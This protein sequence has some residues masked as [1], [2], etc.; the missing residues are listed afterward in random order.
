MSLKIWLPLNGDL[1]NKGASAITITNKG[2]TINNNGKIG[3]CY[4][5]A[6]INL[7]N[8]N[9]LSFDN[10]SYCFWAKTS[11]TNSWQ[12]IIGIDNTSNSQIHGIYVADSARL[13]LEYNPSLNVSNSAIASWHHYAFIVK[14]GQSQCYYDGVLKATSTEAVTN[15]VIGRLRLGVGAAIALNDVRVYDHC[16]SAAEVHEISQGLVLHYKLND[17][18]QNFSKDAN[19][20]WTNFTIGQWYTTL[21]SYSMS[22][23]LA[24][25]G[26]KNGDKFTWSVD[27]KSTAGTKLL[28]ARVQ[29]YNSGSNR[30]SVVG[31][32]ISAGEEGHSYVTFT[33]DTSYNQL[34]FMITNSSSSTVT[35]NTTEQYKN[36]KIQAGDVDTGYVLKGTPSVIQDSSGYGHN[37]TIVNTPILI[38]DTPRYSAAINFNENTDSIK[39]KP[40]FS[41]GQTI[42]ELSVACWF[43][44]NTLNSTAPNIFSLGANA[45]CR[46]RIAS[47]TSIWWYTRVASTSA[48]V[49][50]S[51]KTL[52]DNIWH[53]IVYTFKNG[54]ETMYVDGTSVGTN[55]KTG[56]GTTLTCSS[57]EETYWALAGYSTNSENFIGSESDF[58]IYCTALSA[59]DAKQLYELGAKIDN[60]GEFHTYELVETKSNIIFKAE[61]ARIAQVWADGLGRYTQANCQVTLTDNGYRIYRPPNLTTSANGKTMWGGLRLNNQSTGGI[62]AYNASQDNMWKLQQGHTYLIGFHVKGQSSNSTTFGFSNNMGWDGGGVSPSP[63]ILVND[64]IPTNFNGEKD[65]TCIFTINDTIVKTC[66]SAYSSYT[67]G[68]D[69]LSYRD[70]TFGW[71]Y[72]STGA[73]GTDV[74]LTNLHMYDITS[75]VAKFGKNGVV[76]IGDLNERMNDCRIIKNAELCASEFIEF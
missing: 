12:L 37:G 30:T 72:S 25:T 42:P 17:I 50:K 15:D 60:K 28:S 38:S 49:T 61:C 64:G 35:N 5:P 67:A 8:L 56:T 51:C 11:S 52:T 68:T 63:T 41:S 70:F 27:I 45:F 32:A 34:D 6:T 39:I 59:T 20:S 36:T 19:T 62:H 76:K 2:A 22:D 33:V 46:A 75:L 10:S 9:G 71:G 24:A 65:C 3:Q 21:F 48:G 1:E 18:P 44:T 57:V 43:K 66:T 58:R 40:I 14:N 73:L 54:I 29:H 55:D 74:Y 69:Y 16:L 4:C 7:T 31:N 26:A 47:A 53:H 23:F 13:K